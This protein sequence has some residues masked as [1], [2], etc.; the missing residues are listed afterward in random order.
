MEQELHCDMMMAW[1]ASGLNPGLADS[2]EG[3]LRN[4]LRYGHNPF[5]II[6]FDRPF[7]EIDPSLISRLREIAA[8]T[9]FHI[10]LMDLGRRKEVTEMLGDGFEQDVLDYAL[11]P[12]SDGT[13][14]GCNTNLNLLLSAGCPL[15]STDD[16]I[17]C[18]PAAAL[19]GGDSSSG[20]IPSG[21]YYPGELQYCRDRKAVLAGT[22]EK[23][24]DIIGEYQRFLGKKPEELTERLKDEPG[25]VLT[26]SPGTYG[27]S[28]MSMQS[29]LLKL[30]GLSREFLMKDYEELKYSREL[31]RIPRANALSRSPQFIMAQ[32]GFD[33]GVPLPP[34][35]TFGRNPEGMSLFLTRLIYPASCTLYPA[36]GL[37]HAPPGKRSADRESLY[38][39]KPSLSAL[40]MAAAMYFRPNEEITDID[41]RFAILGSGIREVG[42]L[43]DQDFIEDLH[44]A[45]SRGL[46]NYMDQME[47]I[48]DHQNREPV[49][50]A[51]D[52][53]HHLRSVKALL[54]DPRRMF[55]AEGCGVNVKRARFHFRNYGGLLICWPALHKLMSLQDPPL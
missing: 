18:R 43:S 13:G 23:E 28:C 35:P 6:S 1:P 9:G 3:F 15:I 32:S 50:W 34:F 44:G 30:Q 33:N 27:D 11:Y 2:V 17:F 47:E 8:V 52:M 25:R 39:F 4:A 29:S 37:L 31:I 36:F 41:E 7:S 45:L 55:G 12:S 26:V 20:I 24:I 42:S 40:I 14:Y 53:D 48:L 49:G 54:Q 22:S 16:D 51:D 46:Q 10:S 38:A 5:S 19:S 21:E